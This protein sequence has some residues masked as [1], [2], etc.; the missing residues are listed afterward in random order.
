MKLTRGLNVYIADT[1]VLIA[2]TRN[3]EVSRKIEAI[4]KGEPL[5]IASVSAFELLVGAKPRDIEKIE[6]LLALSEVLPFDFEAAQISAKIVKELEKTGKTVPKIDIFIA[7]TAIKHNLTLIAIDS[8]FERI[9]NLKKII[10][11]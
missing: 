5:I 1:S 4:T 6:R 8:D 9:S 10:V 11:K 3:L 7:A 2:L